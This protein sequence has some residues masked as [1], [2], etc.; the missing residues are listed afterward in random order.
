MEEALPVEEGLRAV[1]VRLA[2][3]TRLVEG[4]PLAEIK[5]DDCKGFIEGPGWYNSGGGG[6]GIT[7]L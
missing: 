3:G 6:G 7:R 2:A 4:I 1:A 5:E